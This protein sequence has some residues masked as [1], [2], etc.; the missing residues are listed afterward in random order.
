MKKIY[1][2]FSIFTII[3][4]VSMVITSQATNYSNNRVSLSNTISLM[5]DMPATDYE[6][7][8]EK[9][10]EL[11]NA[12]NNR[13]SL[14]DSSVMATVTNASRDIPTT[15]SDDTRNE[16]ETAKIKLSSC[17]R[18]YKKGILTYD[19]LYSSINS[20]ICSL[21]INLSG[22]KTYKKSN[23]LI[24]E[25][26]NAISVCKSYLERVKIAKSNNT[27]NVYT[28][29]E[30]YEQTFEALNDNINNLK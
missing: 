27:E 30:E 19:I 6:R 7:D 24:T 28:L 22:A 8:L 25:I 9:T 26:E 2:A 18:A 12:Y 20:H 4:I 10:T 11:L 21:E 5:D 13:A 29:Y 17:Y 16:E 23:E 3:V 1:I 14:N 15:L